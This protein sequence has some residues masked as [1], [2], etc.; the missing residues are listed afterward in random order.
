M[1][2][3]YLKSVIGKMR[4]GTPDDQFVNINETLQVMNS[5]VVLSEIPDEFFGIKVNELFDGIQLTEIK[6]GAPTENQFICDYNLGIIQLHESRNEQRL[7]FEFKGRGAT[8]I[9]ADR[10]FTKQMNNTEIIQTLRDVLDEADSVINLSERFTNKGEYSPTEVYYGRNIVSYDLGAYMCV[11][12]SADGIINV[13]PT[14]TDNWRQIVSVKEAVDYL[15]DKVDEFEGRIDDKI[16]ESG[17]RVDEFEVRVDDKIEE[18]EQVRQHAIEATNYANEQGNFAKD[19]GNDLRENL[20]HKGEYDNTKSYKKGNIVDYYGNSHMCIQDTTVGINPSNEEHWQPIVSHASSNDQSWVATE[21]QTTFTI[22]NGNYAVGQRHLDVWVG[23]V[24]QNSGD[25]FIETSS[26]SFTLSESVPAGTRVYAKWFEGATSIA[27]KHYN[28]HYKGGVDEIDVTQLRN[29][30]ERVN[31]PLAQTNHYLFDPRYF[32]AKGDGIAN[33]TQA[34]QAWLDEPGTMRILR[35]GIYRINSTLVSSISDRTIKTD[36]AVLL[37]DTQDI[38]ALRVTG[39]RNRIS[40]E[41]NGQNKGAGGVFIDGAASCEVKNCRIENLYAI[42]RGAIGIEARTFKGITIE[43]NFI[44]NVDAQSNNNLGDNIGSSRAISVNATQHAIEPH[45]VTNNYIDNIIGEEGDAIHFLFHDGTT[46]PFL[47]AKGL[48]ANNTIKNCNRRAIKIQA[49][50]V[51]VKHNEHFNTL[52]ADQL[53]PAFLIDVIRSEDVVVTDNNIDARLFSGMQIIGTAS[54]KA[55]KCIMRNNTIKGNT[56]SR[57]GMFFDHIEDCNINDNIIY[58]GSTAIAIQNSS[59]S[60]INNNNFHGGDPNK[61]AINIVASNSRITAK[62]NLLLSDGR[63][64]L[65]Q[66]S[67]PDCI[68]EDNHSRATVGGNI[69]TFVTA[70]GSVYRNNT[71]S[72]GTTTVIGDFTN[73]Y[74]S[75]SRNTG[76]GAVGVPDIMFTTDIPSSVQPNRRH[77]RG[78]VAF[79]TLPSAG[80]RIGW[81]CI[82]GGTPGT[83]RQFGAIDT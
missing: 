45:T 81:V 56:E 54:V 34:I 67:A 38:V 46:V 11:N 62:G 44:R 55:K 82:S 20:G 77:N 40:I 32:G 21:G 39:D 57:N 71:N 73:Q 12:H 80:S 9:A 76:S 66:N 17:R 27:L 79:S 43:N 68:I 60:T 6:K 70:T 78:D 1:A 25:G 8:Y 41:V 16:E 10:I 28:S 18:T 65:V 37:L 64:Y 30:E 59:K 58:D 49:S 19:T 22:T 74:H 13:P 23:G 4:K 5:K 48:V 51:R 33:D 72:S 69:R 53:N 15:H 63:L 50:N 7:T 52:T 61:V 29:F 14:D 42:S 31:E 26:T 35:D 3:E 75:G 83:W 47:R 36:G 24:P 2:F